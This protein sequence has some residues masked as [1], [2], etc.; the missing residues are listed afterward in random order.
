MWAV[1]PHTN[2]PRPNFEEGVRGRVP[3]GT[4]RHDSLAST[5]NRIRAS[6]SIAV[7]PVKFGK[8]IRSRVAD[9]KRRPQFDDSSIG[10]L[11]HDDLPLC[12]AA[13]LGDLLDFPSSGSRSPRRPP[14]SSSGQGTARSRPPV[15]TRRR[16]L[17]AASPL[18]QLTRRTI[19]FP[20]MRR[21]IV[22]IL[23]HTNCGAGGATS[24]APSPLAG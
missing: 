15:E 19:S 9:A 7:D 3:R 14:R 12:I 8:E 21:C 2:K 23:R 18:L 6:D 17:V 5:S 1:R 4:P 13:C 10:S 11:L 16:G 24:T 20:A 22:A